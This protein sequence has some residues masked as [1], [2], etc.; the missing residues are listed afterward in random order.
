MSTISSQ[1]NALMKNE[2]HEHKELEEKIS[3]PDVTPK[4]SL[5]RDS[6]GDP[7]YLMTTETGHKEALKEIFAL[8]TPSNG[9]Y[10]GFAFEF[11]YHV[12][13]KREVQKAFICDINPRMHTIY[14]WIAKT[15]VTAK[16]RKD[17]L[18]KF[19][20]ELNKHPEYYLCSSTTQETI[21]H[22]ISHRWS[23]LY[24]DKNYAQIRQ[25]YFEGKIEHRYLNLTDKTG[26]FQDL[27]NWARDN[28][29]VFDI[30]YLSN[31]PEWI[32]NAGRHH[33][34]TMQENLNELLSPST[35]LVDA[36]KERWETGAPKVRV[37][38]DVSKQG[39]PS[40]RPP[41]R[42]RTSKRD[43][44]PACSSFSRLAH[45][46]NRLWRTEF[47]DNDEGLDSKKNLPSLLSL[48]KIREIEDNRLNH[49]RSFNLGTNLTKRL[50]PPCP[51]ID[52]NLFSAT[53]LTTDDSSSFLAPEEFPF[54]PKQP[55]KQEEV[56][57]ETKRLK[58]ATNIPPLVQEAVESKKAPPQ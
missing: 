43:T 9:V 52:K 37:A 50:A 26:Q 15:I 3:P 38:T 16:D 6:P 27:G 44:A 11:N 1:P 58:L 13:A 55:L 17:F 19:E 2:L 36:K 46:S 20:A 29:Y 25:L 47:S 18:E 30:V 12:L 32:W 53:T 28:G 24:S 22:F 40:F 41:K 8:P 42:G 34:Q 56:K 10:L 31:I 45:L 14:N 54:S 4:P 35:L 33:I 48:S 57:S 39:F 7:P 21:E 51:L 49:L 5:N 23:W